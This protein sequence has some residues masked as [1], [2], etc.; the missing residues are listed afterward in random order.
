VGCRNVAVKEGVCITHGAKLQRTPKVTKLQ[1]PPKVTKANDNNPEPPQNVV[2]TASCH[3]NQ[4]TSLTMR[5]N[6]IHGFGGLVE[7]RGILAHRNH[8]K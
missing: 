2:P 5:R 8:A 1:R 7:W 6:L 3:V 4:R